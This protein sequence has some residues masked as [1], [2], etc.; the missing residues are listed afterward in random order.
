[1]AEEKGKIRCEQG[2]CLMPGRTDYP[3]RNRQNVSSGTLRQP[4]YLPPQEIRSGLVLLLK[5]YVSTS[6]EEASREVSRLLGFKA[7]SE[8]LREVME[9]QIDQLLKAG[10]I[11]EDERGISFP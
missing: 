11:Q 10:K 1:M 3:P 4:D 9:K 2:F 7:L 5:A 6:R 8:G